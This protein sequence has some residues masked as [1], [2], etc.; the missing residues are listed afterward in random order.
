MIHCCAS[1]C[2]RSMRH[3]PCPD[4]GF[5]LQNDGCCWCWVFPRTTG[6]L[7]IPC[8]CPAS[9]ISLRV[10]WID[11]SG[12]IP[13]LCRTWRCHLLDSYILCV[14]CVCVFTTGNHTGLHITVWCSFENGFL[15]MP[16]P[17]LSVLCT[18]RLEVDGDVGSS[19]AGESTSVF[20]FRA[21]FIVGGCSRSVWIIF[22]RE[23]LKTC[24]RDAT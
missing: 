7:S 10:L 3:L 2:G 18:D 1:C 15:A 17:L 5:H 19:S 21:G 13:V 4:R 22:I 14:L 20:V 11:M 24:T 6:V 8:L 23:Y 16:P 9:C 12:V